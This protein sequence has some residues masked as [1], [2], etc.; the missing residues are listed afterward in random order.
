MTSSRKSS[1]CDST[2][3]TWNFGFILDGFPRN[4]HQAEFFLES[5]DINAVILIE[6]PDQVVLDRIMNRRLCSKCGLDYNLIF[7]RPVIADI[8]DVCGGPLTARADDTPEAVSK[9]LTDYHTKT[10][11]IPRAVRPQGADRVGGRLQGRRSGAG[12][13]CGGRLGV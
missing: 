10:K 4:R 3:M 7:H 12:P 2:N 6:V 13:S 11:P 5:Y 8:C 1:R 9:R